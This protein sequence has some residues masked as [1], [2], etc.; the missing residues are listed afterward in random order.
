MHGRQPVLPVDIQYGTAEPHKSASLTEYATKLDQRLSSAFGLAS[1]TS[2]VHHK[3]QKQLYDKKAHGDSY[4]V[5]D[6]VWVL[7]PKVPRNSSKKLFHPW[8]GPFTI[9]KQLSECTY[10]IQ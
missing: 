9:V 6:L 5:G 4:A 7:N 1:K 8:N 3:K 10:R 2:G